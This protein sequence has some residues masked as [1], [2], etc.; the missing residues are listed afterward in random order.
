[1]GPSRDTAN[2]ARRSPGEAPEDPGS[3]PGTSTA[4]RSGPFQ[5]EGAAL[6]S[7]A[8]AAH[9]GTGAGA[10][11]GLAQGRAAVREA[12][13][14]PR[15]E[16]LGGWWVVLRMGCR[17]GAS[18]GGGMNSGTNGVHPDFPLAVVQHPMIP[19]TYE[20]QIVQIGRS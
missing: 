5:P 14:V 10:A 9:G 17:S 18:Q 13:A 20:Y 4:T 6:L 19:R 3:I 2:C 7:Q 1:M 16:L 11:V 12:K 15:T 8:G